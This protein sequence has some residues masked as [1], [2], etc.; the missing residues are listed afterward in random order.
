MNEQVAAPQAPRNEPFTYTGVTSEYFRIW[1]VSLCLTVLTLGIYS[2]WAKVRKRRYLYRSTRLAGASFDYHA[3]PLVILRGRLIAVF[4]LLCY[5]GAGYFAPGIEALILLVIVALIPW[6]I[7][8]A[9]MFN[10]RYTSYRNLRFRFDPVYGEAYT[11]IFGWYT[12]AGIT[13][14]LLYPYA[15]YR[16]NAMLVNNAHFG[17]L[18]FQLADVNRGFYG[19]Y[20]KSSLLILAAVIVVGIA[21]TLLPTNPEAGPGSVNA[22]LLIG[23]VA[24]LVVAIAVA[25]S[26]IGPAIAKLII[27]NTHIGEHELKCEWII[28]RVMFINLTNFLAI[29]FSLGLAIPWATIRLQRY[30]FENMS[31]DVRGGIDSIIATQ[32]DEVSAMGEEIGE[33]FDIDIGF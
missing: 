10:A 33:A 17:N 28:P 2:A 30:Q 13:L 22:E 18:D 19:I 16:R 7:V 23:L 1:I 31:I 27:G 14:G 4:M 12:L 21:A 5:V 15:H 11:I 24:G 32:S 20:I 9:R 25:G 26:Y 3:D 29:G 6:L 8:R